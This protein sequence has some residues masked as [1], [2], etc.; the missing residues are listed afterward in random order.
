MEYYIERRTM[1][2]WRKLGGTYEPIGHW[3]IN[4]DQSDVLA[5]ALMIGPFYKEEIA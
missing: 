4:R 5:N 3:T 2:K 1:T